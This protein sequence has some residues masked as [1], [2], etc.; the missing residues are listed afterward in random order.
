MIYALTAGILNGIATFLLKQ[1]NS[2]RP[3]LFVSILFYG[4]NFYLFRL[5]INKINISTAY[6]LL[7]LSTLTFIKILEIFIYKESILLIQL[8]G[9]ILVLLA[10]FILSR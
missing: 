3:L 2:L 6:C 8:F 1:S 10:V 5:A 9:F 4:M 7:V